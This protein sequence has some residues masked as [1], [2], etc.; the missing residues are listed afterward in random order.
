[1]HPWFVRCVC[2]V[3]FASVLAAPGRADAESLPDGCTSGRLQAPATAQSVSINGEC[4]VAQGVYKFRDV[5]VLDKGVLRFEDAKIDFW[6]ANILVENGGKIIAGT[7]EAPIG[8]LGG[9]LTFHL[10]GPNQNG[11]DPSL[12]A[13][14]VICQSDAAG[15]CG[16]PEAI[17]TSNASPDGHMVPP[18]RAR[19]IAQIGATDTY[20]NA[21]ADPKIAADYFYA[22]H[23]LEFD[24]AKDASGRQGY[25][26]YK[27]LGVSYGG[28]L[29]LHGL[30]GASYPDGRNCATAFPSRSANSWARLAESVDP[31]NGG[32]L[33][34]DRPLSFAAGDEI[35][36]TTT[37]YLPGHSE[38]LVVDR[39]VRCSTS[40]PLRQPVRYAHNGKRY[41]LGQTP[42][43][44]GPARESN[45][46][47]VETRAAVGVLS[48]SIRIVSAGD[49]EFDEFPPEPAS[50]ST[51]PG[52]YFGGHVVIRQ[53]FRQV[54]IQGVEFKQLGQGGRIGRYPLHFHHARRAAPD[55]YVRDSSINESMT[56]WIVLHATQDVLLERNVGFKSIG[57]GFYLEDGT[58]T[59]NRLFANLGV[60][61]RAAIDNGQ[62]PRKVPGILAAYSLHGSTGETMPFRSDYDHPTVFWIMNGWNDFQ[63]NMAVGAGT[64]GTCYWLLPGFNG[65]LSKDMKWTSYASMQSSLQRAGMTPLKSFDG[66]FCSTAMT[67]FQTITAT[68]SCQGVGPGGPAASPPTVVPIANPL[69]PPPPAQCDGHTRDRG[70]TYYPALGDGGRFA[71]RCSEEDCSVTPRR[72][73]PGAALADCMVTVLSRYTTSFNWAPFNFA[74]IWLRPQ[75]YLVTDSAITDTQQAGL[76][77]VT[78]GGYSESDVVPGHWALVRKTAFIGHTQENNPYASNGGPFNPLGLKCATDANGNRPGSYCLSI[79]EGISHQV[80]NFG[81]YQRLFSVYD[82]PAYQASNA[83]LNIRHREID[84]CTPFT[85]KP[86]QTGR[87]DPDPA[88]A[89][90]RR[91]SAWLAGAVIGLPKHE[92]ASG[93]QRCYMPNAA[94]GWK[95]P[96]GFYY[97][98]AF[99]SADLYFENVDTRHFVITP[100]MANNSLGTDYDRVAEQYCLW[101]RELF[102]G[103]AGNDRQTVLNDNDG[104]LTGYKD[105]T[106]IN[107]DE[108][109]AAPTDSTECKSERSSR[110]SPYRYV[111]T[112]IYPQCAADGTCAKAPEPG[113]PHWNDGG[114]N[115]ACTSERCYGV[116]LWRQDLMPKADQ[117]QAKAIRMMGQETGQRS[118]LTV[119]GG[120]YYIDTAVPKGEQLSDGCNTRSSESNPC[121]VNVFEAGQTYHLFLIFADEN[122]RQTYR[123]YVGK[124][125]DFEPND[126]QLIQADIGKNPIVYQARGALPAGRARWYDK[127]TGVVEVELRA[128]DLGNITSHLR[129]ARAKHC[130]PESFCQLRGDRCVGVDA[131]NNEVCQWTAAPPDCPDGGCIGFS[132]TLPARFTT[133]APKKSQELIPKPTCVRK[134]GPWRQAL[135]PVGREVDGCPNPAD[136]HPEDFCSD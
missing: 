5:H 25:F 126:I 132:F 127:S 46:D 111:T 30:K 27:V 9:E 24:D 8:T 117:G 103:F 51:S 35:V 81:M 48:R 121:V 50:S 44:V 113:D 118:S 99:H 133:A 97:P 119:N 23:P 47:A 115:R 56:R 116:P 84:D 120:T 78:G 73:G 13:L 59:D 112:V 98:P 92:D 106:V 65:G 74:A 136:L 42:A 108:F 82:G 128:A 61:A 80:S 14:G 28:S 93:Q 63:D 6:A 69:A 58:E 135:I 104:T 91:Q 20:P 64:C 53:G 32:N 1:M 29:L 76:T 105:T 26:G 7:P 40:I 109:F 19:T 77:M 45:Q 34:V 89:N 17:W 39:D 68:E 100:L 37:D 38:Q 66:N 101:N 3:L 55:T 122:T 52:Y 33:Q 36:L 87:C 12:K 54:Q 129:E 131:S 41:S 71:T 96:N 60:F 123:F 83:Y 62:N 10:W 124:D 11:N 134:D 22:Y 79:N 114:W 43:G 49:T 4:K 107:K 95:Q 90:G 94:I 85:D 110:T 15:H 130:K 31:A 16:V 125:T 2:G 75:W 21:A 72:C 67:S 70:C 102:T 57:H 86:N 18:E 88:T